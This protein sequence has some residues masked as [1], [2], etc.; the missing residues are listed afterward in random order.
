[1]V[2]R[3]DVHFVQV[4]SIPATLDRPNL[5]PDVE[6][7]LFLTLNPDSIACTRQD[8][9]AVPPIR[10]R[11]E[12]HVQVDGEHLPEVEYLVSSPAGPFSVHGTPDVQPNKEATKVKRN[13]GGFVATPHLIP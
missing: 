4:E 11:Q 3:T 7:A 12:L 2:V 9:A 8:I 1:M 6:H 10:Y 13:D 5:R